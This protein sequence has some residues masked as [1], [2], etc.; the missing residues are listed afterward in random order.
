MSAPS[1]RSLVVPAGTITRR[2]APLAVAFLALA[3]CTPRGGAGTE[4]EPVSAPGLPPIALVEGPL[5]PRVQYPAENQAI[6]VRD[7][8]FV[9]GSVGNGRASLTING[10]PVQV[11]P[12]GAFIAFLPVPPAE[13]PAYEL[14]A[15]LGADTARFTRRLRVAPP[16]APLDSA[17][18]VDSA[19]VSPRAAG[20]LLRA[21]EP[22]RVSVRTSADA[23]AWVQWDTAAP[24]PV[25]P[26]APA[27]AARG[28][29]TAAP[30]DTTPP[31]PPPPAR[32]ALLRG[33]GGSWSGDLRAGALA[34]GAVLVV[35]RGA[36]SARFP[37]ARI[38]LLDP[39][40]PPRL[41][42][43]GGDS[44]LVVS[45]TDRAIP[46]R[47][48][49]AGGYV[50]ALFPGTVVEVTG[51]Q[52]AFTRF[53]LDDALEAWVD[54][55]LTAP[56]PAGSTVSRP[57]VNSF[58]LVPAAGWVDVRI[59][60]PERMPYLVQEE[61][62]DLVL[63][64]YGVRVGPSLVRFLE[65]D[66]LVRYATWEQVT[67][68]RAK[69]RLHLAGRPYGYLA[70]HERGQFTLRVRR[71]PA[72]DRRRPLA[73]I[74]VAIDAGH[75]PA[76][77]TG[78]TGLY[79]GDAM[80]PVADRAAEL[81]RAKGANVVRIR[82]TLEPYPLAQRSIDARRADAHAFVS[83]HLNALGDGVNPFT[84]NGSSVLYFHP[85]AEPLARTLETELVRQFRLRDLGVHF[86]NIAIGRTTWMPS[87]ITEGLF[88]MM[89]EQEAAMR[90]PEG[91]EKYARAVADGVEAYFRW[92]AAQ[93]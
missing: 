37:L 32:Q 43:L 16:R 14:V 53:R 77:A 10:I 21:D 40:A 17:R 78:P 26:P 8:N 84:N 56:R 41:A 68:G 12:N 50:W 22:V 82:T 11:A 76:G 92:L 81:L 2:I 29:S 19:S 54:T 1:S 91:R 60:L 48:F 13:A 93:Q 49:P 57:S 28:R 4:P 24:R 59:P 9:H 55:E 65:N 88:I 80:L 62:D 52:G 33:N 83:L 72:V 39:S 25:Q 63:T 31:A 66:S 73:G 75:P 3:A 27:P 74:T 38:E 30:R 67:N 35:A 61:G 44:A 36:D 42:I 7:S 64:L 70:F 6:D 71:P 20:M 18:F 23:E 46:A 45:D 79:E 87:V 89:P 51:M 86:Q 69:L 90:S 58:N 5:Q 85:Q 15:T 34:R 47:A